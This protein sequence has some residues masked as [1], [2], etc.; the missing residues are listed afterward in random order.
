MKKIIIKNNFA[1]LYL[2]KKFYDLK[3]INNTLKIYKDFFKSKIIETKMYNIVK[4][5]KI[6]NEFDLKTLSNEFL[7]YLLSQNNKL[8]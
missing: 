7:N 1:F 2:N 5:K 8:Q 3:I 4:I 6:N